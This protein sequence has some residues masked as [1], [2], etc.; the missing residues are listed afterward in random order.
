MKK[1]ITIISFLLLLTLAACGN[2][3]KSN[4]LVEVNGQDVTEEDLLNMFQAALGTEEIPDEAFE[5]YGSIFLQNIVTNKLLAEEGKSLK[6][7][8]DDEA[9]QNEL[10]MYKQLSGA[11]TD[12]QFLEVLK[13]SFGIENEETFIDQYIVPSVVIQQLT[14]Q[15]SEEEVTKHFNEQKEE[16]MQVR[17]RHI[18]VEDEQQAKDLYDQLQNGAD[19]EQLARENSKDYS[20]DEETGEEKGIEYTFGKGIMVQEFEQQAFSQEVGQISEP[21]KTEYGYHIIETLEK[22]EPE[23]V[24]YENQIRQQIVVD[25]LL[26][27]AEIKV[28]DSRFEGLFE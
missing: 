10:Q 21:I 11:E 25:R 28:L 16:Y 19:F 14:Q 24:D 12:E 22:I 27:D 23:L 18:L 20:K 7:S 1:L 6:I 3:T 2:E 4:V 13:T 9:V 26:A 17:A 5:L 15:L 8:H